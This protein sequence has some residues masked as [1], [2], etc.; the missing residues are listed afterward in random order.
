MNWCNMYKIVN[1]AAKDLETWKEHH[2]HKTP[3]KWTS[4]IYVKAHCGSNKLTT[5][6]SVTVTVPAVNAIL[7][8]L[9]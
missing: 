5:N 2:F 4:T 9:L 7:N 8:I 6:T 3:V 1:K